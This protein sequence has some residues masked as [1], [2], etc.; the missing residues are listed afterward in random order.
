MC[1]SLSMRMVSEIPQNCDPHPFQEGLWVVVWGPWSSKI[2]GKSTGAYPG[3]CPHK[4][5]WCS[6]KIKFKEHIQQPLHGT[7]EVLDYYEN[8]AKNKNKKWS[9][10]NELPSNSTNGTKSNGIKPSGIESS[11]H[12]AVA[13]S[14][15]EQW[16][17][18][19]G[20]RLV[21]L[22]SL[23]ML[24]QWLHLLILLLPWTV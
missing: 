15:P 13:N 24:P 14:Q 23:L 5:C 1:E 16:R 2:S 7:K 6:G 17:K 8:P 3:L 22:W 18:D 20:H 21:Q 11:I 9:D 4:I 10:E 12:G 19:N